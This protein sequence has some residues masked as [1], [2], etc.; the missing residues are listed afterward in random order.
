MRCVHLAP[1]I[2]DL[3]TVLLLLILTPGVG[4]RAEHVPPGRR[5]PLPW[6]TC[7]TLSS[8]PTASPTNDFSLPPTR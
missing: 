8:S 3:V 4:A 2:R 1:H 5:V 7:P 6:A